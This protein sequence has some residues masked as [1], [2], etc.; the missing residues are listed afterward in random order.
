MKK[1]ILCFTVVLILSS[2][3]VSIVGCGKDPEPDPVDP[4]VNYALSIAEADKTVSLKVVGL[5]TLM[6]QAG[7]ALPIKEGKLGLFDHIYID[8]GDNQSLS[9]NLSTFSA[10]MSNI[11]SILDV[12][13]SKD[14]VLLD[15]LGTG[16]DPKEGEVLG[17]DIVKYLVEHGA[18][19]NAKFDDGQTLLLWAKK[20]SFDKEIIDYLI[21]VGAKE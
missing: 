2:A 3:L 9:D 18:D 7:L 10:H 15:E 5:L 11:A 19:V 12:V 4:V 1:N 17:L 8:I 21:S 16:T 6:N 14:L 13:K 20:Y